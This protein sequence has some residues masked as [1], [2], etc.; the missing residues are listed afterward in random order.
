MRIPTFKWPA[1]DSG[2]WR[3]KRIYREFRIQLSGNGTKVWS[4]GSLLVGAPAPLGK[5]GAEERTMNGIIYLVGLI[6]II[7]FILSFLGLR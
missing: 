6:V 7:M 5:A 4:P 2:G 1:R 3:R